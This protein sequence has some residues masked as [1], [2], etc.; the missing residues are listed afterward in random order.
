MAIASPSYAFNPEYVS[1]GHPL[2][3][4]DLRDRADAMEQRERDARKAAKARKREA[5][6]AAK[7][8]RIA[9]G[10][11][12]RVAQDESKGFASVEAA[13]TLLAEQ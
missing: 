5:K 12:I 1:E 9:L 3:A 8:K 10:A 7:C 4:A 2:T 13:K 11:L 6:A